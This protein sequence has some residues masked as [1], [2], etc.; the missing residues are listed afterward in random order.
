MHDGSATQT[1]DNKSKTGIEG[2]DK[3]LRGGLP[4]NRLYVVEGSPGSGKTTLALQFLLEGIRNG[5]TVL[6]V[7]LSETAEELYEVA[8]SHSWSLEGIQL[9]E[10]DALAERIREDT[11]YTV[12]HPADVELVETTRRIREEVERI[13]PTRVALDSV[14]ELKIL[15][16]TIARYRREILGFKQFFV[17][18]RCTVMVLDDL[19]SAKNEQQLQSIAHGVI[20]MERETR[21]YGT[22]RRQLHII[23]MRAIPFRDGLHDFVIRAGG[24]EVFPRLA[25]GEQSFRDR[26]AHSTIQSGV[27]ELDTLLGDGLDRSS[28][29]LILGPA[30]CGKTTISAQFMIAALGRGEP[31][32]AYLFEERYETFL[33]RAMGLGMDF[34]A[35]LESGLLELVQIDPAEVSPGEFANHIHQR[36]ESRGVRM[37]VVDSLNGYINAMPRERFL[38]IQMHELLTYLGEKGVV[39]LLVMA[40]HGM[41][42]TM[43][44]TPAPIDVSFLADTVILLRYFEAQG[45]IRQAISVVK[46]RRG[47]HE[48][49]IRELQLTPTGV[50]VGEPLREFEGVLTGVPRYRG[51]QKP[52]LQET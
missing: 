31:V 1:T 39:T 41:M 12:Y 45:A 2:L 13:R 37:V 38:M 21:D 3:I 30:G 28:S 32:L 36:V 9:L 23:K 11:D 33:Q 24:I 27:Q 10:L 50:L 51:S 6:Y 25:V 34:E 26:R 5:E 48:R 44:S 29:T 15:S 49:T 40:Q 17:G 52:L 14:S 8:R 7:T 43:G 20:R 16:Q 18:K 4:R 42:G 35:H 46:K 22:T 19:T 47:A